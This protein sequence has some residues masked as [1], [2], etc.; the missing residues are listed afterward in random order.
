MGVYTR[1]RASAAAFARA[2]RED[3]AAPKAAGTL[4][5]ADG[6]NLATHLGC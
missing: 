5:A 6:Y 2:W 3:L 1:F 4:E